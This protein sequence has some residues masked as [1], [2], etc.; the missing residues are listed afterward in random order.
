MD[1][2]ICPSVEESPFLTSLNETNL[3]C[4]FLIFIPRL[5]FT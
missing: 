4:N 1:K 5:N 2:I 3:V